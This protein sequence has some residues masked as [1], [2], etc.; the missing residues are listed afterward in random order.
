MSKTV[1]NARN[2]RQNQTDAEKLLWSKLRNRQFHDLKFRRQHPI[3]PYIIDFFCEALQIAIELDGGQHSPEVDAKR[4][5]F[6]EEQ[7]ITIIRFWNNDVLS[8]LE[9]VL[10]DLERIIPSPNPLPEGEDFNAEKK[11]CIARIAAPHGIKGLVKIL[12]YAEDLSLIEAVQEFDITLKNPSG[13]YILAEIAGVN[14]REAVEA[15]KGTELYVDRAAL[16]DPDDGEYYIEDLVGMMCVQAESGEEIGKVI[17]V[18]NY[19]AGDLL[20]IK[21]KS[22]SKYHGAFLVPFNDETVPEISD[23]IKLQNFEHFL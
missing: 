15:I 12:P 4:Q 7:G 20:E 6:I 21:P 17:A 5:A 10:Q 1:K 16:P 2:L 18:P 3:P 13:K 23:T 14:S 22:G 11:I 8:N 9:G 19:G